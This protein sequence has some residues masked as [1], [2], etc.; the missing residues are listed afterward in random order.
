MKNLQ[1]L[2]NQM[3]KDG[4]VINPEGTLYLTA[5][6]SSGSKYYNLK[7][8]E[9]YSAERAQ[10][11][12]PTFTNIEVTPTSLEFTTYRVD[13]M[14]VT[15]TYKIVKDPSIEVV[16]PAIESKLHLKHTGNVVPTEPSTFYPE[17]H[18]TVTGKNVNGGVYDIAYEDIT[19]KTNPEGQISISQDGKVTVEEGAEP[20]EVQVWAEVVNEG[21]TLTTEKVTIE[22]V[23]HAE[24]TI[25]E[26]GSKWKYLDDGS[27]QGTAW[28]ETGFDDSSWKSGAST[29]RIFSSQKIVQCLV[30]LIRLLAMV[31]MQEIKFQLTIS[32]QHLK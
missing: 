12:A 30:M 16:L 13:T 28:R 18:L 17:V 7:D 1:P 11:R 20:G 31:Q 14:E 4:S 19:Y 21:K 23:E 24:Q 10:L 2:K 25:L 22:I 26:K 3:V 15:D 27:D 9:L 29:I 5:N 6:S 8:P 32:E